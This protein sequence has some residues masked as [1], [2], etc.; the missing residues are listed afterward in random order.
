M[1]RRTT[2]EGPCV[3]GPHAGKRLAHWS[4][5]CRIMEADGDFVRCAGH[6][7]WS[8][9]GRYWKWEPA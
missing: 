2:Y 3:E 8:D 5:S 6:Y 1:N 9:T 4:S 7:L